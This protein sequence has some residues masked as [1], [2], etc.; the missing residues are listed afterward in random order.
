MPHLPVSGKLISDIHVWMIHIEMSIIDKN[1]IKW[2][3]D[4]CSLPYI[5][6][7]EVKNGKMTWKIKRGQK[8]NIQFW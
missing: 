8:F 6:K 2:N 7:I 5:S 4:K 1:K 3:S